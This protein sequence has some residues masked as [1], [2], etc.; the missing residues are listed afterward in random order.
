MH[1]DR[2]RCGGQ[3]NDNNVWHVN[4]LNAHQIYATSCEK[5]L[6]ILAISVAEVKPGWVLPR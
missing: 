6:H 2:K 4:V 1:A 5:E 3:V